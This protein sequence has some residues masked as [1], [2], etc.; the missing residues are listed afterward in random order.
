M[1]P[2][3]RGACNAIYMYAQESLG[4]AI[5]LLYKMSVGGATIVCQRSHK[6]RTGPLVAIPKPIMSIKLPVTKRR[7]NWE[8][9]VAIERKIKRLLRFGIYI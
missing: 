9:S 2:T 7:Q 4:D 6:L 5:I 3:D 1:R 8:Y